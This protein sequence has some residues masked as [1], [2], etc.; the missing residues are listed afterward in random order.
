MEASTLI[1]L[2]PSVQLEA[3]IYD[4]STAGLQDAPPSEPEG[5]AI[6]AHPYG[7][8]GG[9][10]D[11]HVVCA[12]AEHLLVQ[13]RFEV[14]TYNSRGVGQSTG[15]ASWTGAAEADDYQVRESVLEWAMKRFEERHPSVR[16]A[17]LVLCGYSAGSL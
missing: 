16:G 17:K 6:I 14:V 5:L 12:L 4:P 15:R 7:S 10:F 2:S 13:R 3:R 8:L 11:D 1:R 9:S